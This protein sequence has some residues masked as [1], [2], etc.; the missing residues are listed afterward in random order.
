MFIETPCTVHNVLKYKVYSAQCKSEPE[1][2][3]LSKGWNQGIEMR[4]L[5][6]E[7]LL[8]VLGIAGSQP[9]PDTGKTFF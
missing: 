5:E 2:D 1:E 3:W 9:N 8:Q 4:T 6:P 7:T